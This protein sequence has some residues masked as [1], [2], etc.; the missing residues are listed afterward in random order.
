MLDTLDGLIK[1][2]SSD[3]YPC[4]FLGSLAGFAYEKQNDTSG[5]GGLRS[6]SMKECIFNPLMIPVAI[7]STAA[8]VV[9]SAS[10]LDYLFLLGGLGVGYVVGKVSYAFFG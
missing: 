4:L 6:F 9:N 8:A 7:G 3:Y 2:L 1:S 5:E 10:L